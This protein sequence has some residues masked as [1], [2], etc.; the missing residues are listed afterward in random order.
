MTNHVRLHRTNLDQMIEQMSDDEIRAIILDFDGLERTGATGDGILR[1]TAR[2]IYQALQGRSSGFDATYMMMV[3]H[4][5]HK[6]R[7]SRMIEAENALDNNAALIGDLCNL[8]PDDVA[9][10]RDLVRRARVLRGES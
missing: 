4:S 8:D 6:I 5:A 9:A 7:S 2:R 3:G 10:T 1:E